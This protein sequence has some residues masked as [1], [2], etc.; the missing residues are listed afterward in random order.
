MLCSVTAKLTPSTYLEPMP[1]P[2]SVTAKSYETLTILFL[3]MLLV[4]G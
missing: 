2:K 3:T 4:T 1:D